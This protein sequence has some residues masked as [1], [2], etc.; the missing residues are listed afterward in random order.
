[1]KRLKLA[2]IG[3]AAS[4]PL[5]APASAQHQGHTMMPGMNM[6]VPAKKPPAKKPAAK[7]PPPKKAAAKKVAPKPAANKAV[8]KKPAPAKAKPTAKPKLQAKPPADPLAGHGISSMPGMQAPA[9][10]M[11]AMPGAQP[12][13]TDLP[14]GSGPAPPTPSANAAD[15]VYGTD[16]MSMGRHHLLI[17]H[18]G[19]KL[20]QLRNNI[21]EYQAR[22]GPDGYEWDAE[23]SY[24]GDINRVWL[25]SQG[26]G[27][28]GGP[29]GRAEI[30]A[31][32]SRAIDPYWNI[33]GGLRYDF[34]PNPSRVFA[35]IGV[36]GL[37]P[38]F[39]D[40]EGALFV[41][42]KGEFMA[43]AEGYY[44]QRITQRLIVQP[45][46]ELNLAAQNSRDLGVGA[47]LSDAELGVRLRYDIRREFAP[48]IGV[49]YQRAF[50]KTREFRRQAGEDPD[51]I[52]LVV[53]VR[54]WF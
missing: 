49:N 22:K 50:G 10:D 30:Q 31:L 29:L 24:G 38:S 3:A 21:S 8:A 53:G 32:Y 19:Q 17:H 20:F 42:N 4:L 13:G 12:S 6:P 51:G 16:A 45:R 2:L 52:A 40:L 11:G 23:A 35:T 48:Y 33:Q 41:S 28:V 27:E 5:T 44:D 7:K 34:K 46:I 9:H 37:A 47:G 25:K 1:M 18:G 26:D 15:A 54:T 43:R 14:A 36:E 39:F